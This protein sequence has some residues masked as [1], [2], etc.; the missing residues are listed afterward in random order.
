MSDHLT[1]GETV[2]VLNRA[3]QAISTCSARE[4]L[5]QMQADA[6]TALNTD[7]GAMLPTRWADW[8]KLNVPEGYDGVKTVHGAIRIPRIIVAINY[9]RVQ[10]TAPR[11]NMR[12]LRERDSDT[13]AYTGK[14]LKPSECSMEHVEPVS[15]GGK[16]QW[17]N[18]VLAD[19]MVNSKR[20]NLSLEKAG[21]RL[22]HVPRAPKPKLPS[23]T[24]RNR[25]NVPEWDHFLVRTVTFAE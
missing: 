23:Q 25:Y 5:L 18:I 8:A 10:V 24:I 20:G 6:A 11:L 15:K 1:R 12:S 19:R 21:L 7:G 4:A 9:D 22:R 17:D 13:C 14:K 2:L 16:T 3:W